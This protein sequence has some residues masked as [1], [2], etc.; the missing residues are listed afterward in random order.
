MK[1]IN[2]FSF[3]LICI[4]YELFWISFVAYDV[5][6][7]FKVLIYVFLVNVTHLFT[8]INILYS[9]FVCIIINYLINLFVKKLFN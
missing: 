3:K 2:K 9:Q 8:L 4:Q 7:L 6:F 5:G 1:R